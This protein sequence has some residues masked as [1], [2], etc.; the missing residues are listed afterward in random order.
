MALFEQKVAPSKLVCQRFLQNRIFASSGSESK[1][2][3]GFQ[4]YRSREDVFHFHTVWMLKKEEQTSKIENRLVFTVSSLQGTGLI[5]F[6]KVTN[7]ASKLISTPNI[8]GFV[9]RDLPLPDDSWTNDFEWLFLLKRKGSSSLHRNSAPWAISCF[10]AIS[11][12]FV[13]WKKTRKI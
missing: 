5:P 1:S 8:C 7:K 2:T 10:P 9:I 13:C 11:L 6:Q 3:S 12:K 4:H